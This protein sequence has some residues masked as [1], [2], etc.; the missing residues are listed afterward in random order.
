VN[1][2]LPAP[3]ITILRMSESV[4]YRPKVRKTDSRARAAGHEREDQQVL[5]AA[6]AG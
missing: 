4:P 5:P 6:T 3:M 1:S 2:T